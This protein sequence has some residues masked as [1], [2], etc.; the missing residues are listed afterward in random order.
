[1]RKFRSQKVEKDLKK[2]EMAGYT[3]RPSAIMVLRLGE[4]G[5]REHHGV[6][7]KLRSA[8][9]SISCPQGIIGVY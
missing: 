7:L 3:S 8:E 6:N 9:G 4:K 5:S 2:R 1:M